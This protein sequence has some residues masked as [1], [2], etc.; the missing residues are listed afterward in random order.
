[1]KFRL[2]R[3]IISLAVLVAVALPAPGTASATNRNP[4]ASIPLLTV[5]IPLDLSTLDAAKE[6]QAYIIN[7]LTLETLLKL[8]PQG[9]LEPDLATSWT[10][11]SPV[12]Y[13]YHLR[14]GVKFWDGNQL[15]SADVVYSWDHYR[16]KGSL[17]AFAFTALKSV[18]AQGP[19]SVVATLNQPNAA[20]QFVPALFSTS[21][22]EMKFAEA[23]P[24]TY[25]DSGSLIM[26]TG[27]WEVDSFDPTSGAELSANPGW[28]GGTVPVQHITF[29]FFS[30][31]TSL[32][33]AFRAGE[34]DLDPEVDNPRTFAATSGAKLLTTPSCAGAIFSMNT[35]VSPWNDIHVR[36]AVAYA[37]NRADIIKAEGGYSTPGYTLI[38]TQQ[39]LTIA[40]EG[41]IDGLLKLLPLYQYNL[42]KAKQEMAESAYPNGV[43]VTVV[44]DAG[45]GTPDLAGQ[46]IEAELAKI[47]I[48]VQLKDV[49]DSVWN[50]DVTGLNGPRPADFTGTACQSPDPSVASRN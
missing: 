7:Q 2:T 37:I 40:S 24:G 16:A 8:G 9:Q 22:F 47:G 29:K 49:P 32:A 41:Q 6:E 17:D 26:G 21:I 46:V 13:V 27:P 33:L 35:R 12:T 25:G 23:H 50:A 48:S 14:Q 43:K 15:T 19:Y 28:W 18:A 20:W 38:H 1:V 11:T 3:L 42:S 36:R 4:S 10:E 39:L 45:Q 34:I 31:E 30:N 44:D 5:G